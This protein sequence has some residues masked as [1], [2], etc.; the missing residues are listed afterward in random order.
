M[1]PLSIRVCSPT[2]C[3]SKAVSPCAETCHYSVAGVDT[4]GLLNERQRVIVSLS[5][6]WAQGGQSP[7]IKVIGVEVIWSASPGSLNL[8]FQNPWRDGSHDARRYMVLN[9]EHVLN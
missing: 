7:E 2:V 1:S 8:D 9:L 4:E 3:C 5:A 6:H